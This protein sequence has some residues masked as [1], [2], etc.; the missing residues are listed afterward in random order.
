MIERERHA[1]GARGALLVVA[2]LEALAVLLRVDAD[3]VRPRLAGEVR[4]LVRLDDEL[5]GQGHGGLPPRSSAPALRRAFLGQTLQALGDK[6]PL[7]PL[8]VLLAEPAP[9]RSGRGTDDGTDDKLADLDGHD[10]LGDLEVLVGQ[11]QRLDDH[12]GLHG[13]EV[14]DA[15]LHRPGVHQGPGPERLGLLVEQDD[16]DRLRD[17]GEGEV[18]LQRGLAPQVQRHCLHHHPPPQDEVGVTGSPRQAVP[19]PVL[20]ALPHLLHAQL[21]G[22][23]RGLL[24]PRV[25]LRGQDAH[26]DRVEEA[27]GGVI[28][29]RHGAGLRVGHREALVGHLD[30]LHG[31]LVPV[32]LQRGPADLGDPR[33]LQRP[34][35]RGLLLLVQ[36]LHH[37]RDAGVG[38]HGD[39]RVPVPEALVVDEDALLHRDVGVLGDAG[40][41]DRRV[42]RAVAVPVLDDLRL[43]LQARHFLKGNLLLR[44]PAHLKAEARKRPYRI[45]SAAVVCHGRSPLCLARTIPAAAA[46]GCR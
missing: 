10:G 46:A 43:R 6:F 44:A 21:H 40:H 24:E 5:G 26:A 41:L 11:L 37:H 42:V 9:A 8:E 39:L 28:G 12:L 14:R 23:A 2:D 45:L 34:H 25:R 31:H 17:D 1:H 19:E 7:E 4:R 38:V 35:H 13:V 15:P 18:G 27:N 29:V 16:L 20:P 32:R 36:E 33:V 22:Q 3:G 30:G